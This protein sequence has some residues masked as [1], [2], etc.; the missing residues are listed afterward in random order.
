MIRHIL[1]AVSSLLVLVLLGAFAS[2]EETAEWKYYQK[3]YY[4]RLAQL[5]NDPKAAN[6]PLKIQQTWNV[7]LDR[8][9]RCVTCHMGID[10]P[11]FAGEKQPLTTHPH[12]IDAKG[13]RG[14]MAKHPFEKLGCTICHNGDGQATRVERTH[15]V[16]HH[17][18]RQ[19]LTGAHVQSACTKCH[20]ELYSQDVYWPET[21]VLMK[22][23]ALARELGCGACH[24][25][26]QMGSSATLAPELSALGS[27]TEL[28]FY[29][30]HDFSHIDG[31]HI[32]RQWEFE[33]FKDPQKIVPGTP[34]APDPKD[35]TS[36][37]IMPNW[38]LTDE[39]AEALTVFVLSL[40]DPKIERIPMAYLPRI[41]GH[42]EF[43]Q[44]RQ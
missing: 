4:K 30:V 17:L 8:A 2:R 14:Y 21:P 32:T 42:E 35:R 16:V 26:R 5:T 7:E 11:K 31:P 12:F 40:K 3:A 29:L 28:A 36:P 41:K 39:E 43:I 37:T 18:D 34:N 33:H 1:F 44:Y 27:K 6:T 25:I 24:T 9:D 13:E 15:G 20:L 19:L 22:G 10:N 23:R 38:G